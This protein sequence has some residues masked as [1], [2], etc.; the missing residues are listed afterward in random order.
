MRVHGHLSADQ[1]QA[2]IAASGVIELM[3]AR[4]GR[5]CWV[6]QDDGASRDREKTTKQFLEF[7]CLTLSSDLHWFANSPDRNVS[8]NLWVILKRGMTTQDSG[9]VDELWEEVRKA[10]NNIPFGQINRLVESFDSRI[11]GAMVRHGE[12]RNGQGSVREM[13]ADGHILEEIS[14]L[15]VEEKAFRGRFIRDSP[16]FFPV[17]GW[18]E[19]SCT[20]FIRES[21]PI[22]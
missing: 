10:W 15:R 9:T 16:I 17:R 21:L 13:L 1:Y 22:V 7:L 2:M 12:S 19:L 6:F 3:D 4:H 20:D 11:Q 5:N 8:E 18:N 14:A